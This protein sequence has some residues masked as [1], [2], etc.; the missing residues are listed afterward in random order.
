[1]CFR[2]AGSDV[3]FEKEFTVFVNALNADAPKAVAASGARRAAGNH[4][5]SRRARRGVAPGV[6]SAVDGDLGK[7][8]EDR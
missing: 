2:S 5:A 4:S 3:A 8:F 7:K 1:M 6:I